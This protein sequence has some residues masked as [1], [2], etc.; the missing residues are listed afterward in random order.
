MSSGE[1]YRDYIH[2]KDLAQNIVTIALKKKNFGIIN[3][4]SGK[5]IQIKK[6]VKKWK[7]KYKLKINFKFN[8]LS[9]PSYES[10]KF[11][12]NKKKLEKVLK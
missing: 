1:Q 12:G 9:M 11:W 5:P 8:S 2:I 4:C 3:V 7:I 6:L 10:I